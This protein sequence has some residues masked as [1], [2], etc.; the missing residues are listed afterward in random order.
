MVYTSHFLILLRLKPGG[1][2]DIWVLNVKSAIWIVVLTCRIGVTRVDVLP[3]GLHIPVT[4]TDLT[5][6]ITGVCL[7][8]NCFRFDKYSTTIRHIRQRFYKYSAYP[9]KTRHIRERFDIFDIFHKIGRRVDKDP[10]HIWQ[11]KHQIPHNYG[12]ES[13]SY[14]ANVC[15]TVCLKDSLTQ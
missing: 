14:L 15:G 12:A 11:K 5:W 3:K 8:R 6:N 7:I 9:R 10:T 13:L 4:H 2:V 1:G